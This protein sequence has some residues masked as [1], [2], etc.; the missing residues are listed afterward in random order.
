MSG[1]VIAA[2]AVAA[3]SVPAPAPS[4]P[5]TPVPSGFR[6]GVAQS[7]FQNEG[8]APD[9]NWTRY[10]RRD[11]ATDPGA[12]LRSADFR[13]R[14][15][16]DVA[17]AAGLGVD[18]FRFS[19]E[20]SRVEPGD[21]VVDQAELA[22][23]DD[24]VTAVRAAGMT[25]MVTLDHWVY[26]GWMA[27]RGGWT[28]PEMPQRW[29]R[30]AERV[31]TRY[32]GLGVMWVTINEPTI[33]LLNE[34]TRKPLTPAGAETMRAALVETHRAAYDL[35]HRLDPGAPVTATIAYLPPPLQEAND[36]AFI[37]QVGDTLDLVGIDY[38]YGASLDNL[39]VLAG[40]GEPWTIRP[41]PDG[42]YDA[43]RHYH[44]K[45]PD[46]PLYV[47]ENG[48]PLDEGEAR[49]DGYRR[50]DSIRDHV[51]WI[52]RAIDDGVP[53]I[54][55]NHWT[56][57]DNDEWG[58]YRARFGLYEVDVLTDPTLERRPTDGVEAY[59]TVIADGGVGSGYR[60][61]QRPAFCSLQ[62]PDRTCTLERLL[63]LPT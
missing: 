30:N 15:R 19:I 57:V 60:P 14:Y 20:W 49:P 32:A 17:L 23:Y 28:D 53:V 1:V 33:Y 45:F 40:L 24:L 10:H 58:G 22:Y 31:V 44:R 2:M 6:W 29:L 4:P 54:G 46:L 41:M 26:P 61:R 59:R 38:Y 12:A 13:N 37:D 21:G 63:G 7:G 34:A 18:T 47:T 48:L 56:L 25:P 11:L 62:D 35:I 50:S 8:S 16:E 55:Y 52:Q 39:S 3:C 36:A 9:S 5:M 42:L 27:D 51:Y 43:L